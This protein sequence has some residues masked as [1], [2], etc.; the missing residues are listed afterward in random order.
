MYILVCIQCIVQAGSEAPVALRTT[1][2]FPRPDLFDYNP[3]ETSQHLFYY[4]PPSIIN[5]PTTHCNC[6]KPGLMVLQWQARRQRGAA[7][8]PPHAPK[9]SKMVHNFGQVLSI[10]IRNEIL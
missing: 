8:P 7:P 4:I 5:I 9:V 6:Y 10:T 2:I 3:D 1:T